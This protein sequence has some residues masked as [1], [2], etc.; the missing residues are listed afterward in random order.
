[1]SVQQVSADMVHIGELSY[2]TRSALKRYS[3]MHDYEEW[4]DDKLWLSLERFAYLVALLSV[5]VDVPW[6][7]P[8]GKWA[9]I[10]RMQD[11]MHLGAVETIKQRDAARP[12]RLEK[13]KE[14]KK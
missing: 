6:L 4:L 9:T 14:E 8:K 1:M 11:L 13:D 10:Q 5:E 12:E 3:D 7:F 2:E